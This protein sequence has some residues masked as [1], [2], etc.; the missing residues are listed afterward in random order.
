VTRLK[1][2]QDIGQKSRKIVA[3]KGRQIIDE[4]I[5]HLFAPD[6]TIA[7]VRLDAHFATAEKQGG[8]YGPL[9]VRQLRTTFCVF[10]KSESRSLSPL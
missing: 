5:P 1:E 7:F 2:V 9:R 10:G 6:T 4:I 3:D 8:K